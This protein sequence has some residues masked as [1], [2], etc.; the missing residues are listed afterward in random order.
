MEGGRGGHAQGAQGEGAEQHPAADRRARLLGSF[1][2]HAFIRTP[3]ARKGEGF[4]EVRPRPDRIP[5]PVCGPAGRQTVPSAPA[6]AARKAVPG[7]RSG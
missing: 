3:R 7:S 2:M 6:R 5:C 4:A 1:G